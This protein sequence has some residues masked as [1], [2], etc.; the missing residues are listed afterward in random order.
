[1]VGRKVGLTVHCARGPVF[2]DSA[3]RSTPLTR[4]CQ[5]TWTRS[6][7]RALAADPARSASVLSGTLVMVGMGPCWVMQ[8][9]VL[10]EAYGVPLTD[11][12]LCVKDAAGSVSIHQRSEG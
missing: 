4:P 5:D 7:L 8:D 6:V 1:M 12:A 9:H 3:A 2:V 11:V 10:T